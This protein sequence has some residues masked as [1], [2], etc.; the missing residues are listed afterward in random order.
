ETAADFRVF[1]RIWRDGW[2]PPRIIVAGLAGGFLAGWVRPGQAIAGA[3]PARW[4]QLFGSVA[5]LVGSVQAAF[6]AGEA[7][8][9]AEDAGVAARTTEGAAIGPA[10]AASAAAPVGRAAVDR[11]R[12]PDPAWDTPPPPAEAATELSETR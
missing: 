3:E 8:E 12:R 10:P 4:L 1:G 7:K 5:G 11:G 6:A 9:A 2:S